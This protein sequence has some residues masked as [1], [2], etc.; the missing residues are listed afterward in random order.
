M[1]KQISLGNNA[2]APA[3]IINDG[4]APDLVCLHGMH[5]DINIVISP[6]GDGIGGNVSL[7]G[8]GFGFQSRGDYGAAQVAARD[9][10]DQ[11]PFLVVK[12]NRHRAYIMVA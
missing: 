4:Y 7:D 2:N 5:A 6:A 9:D 3:F 12:N 1:Q 10:A 11:L 8:G